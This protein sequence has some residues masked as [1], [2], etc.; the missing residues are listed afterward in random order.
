MTY[1]YSCQVC[2][3][4]W[5]VIKTVSEMDRMEACP[6]CQESGKRAFIPSRVYLS[7]TKVQ[8]PEW[9]PAFGQVVNNDY[10]RSELAKEKGYVEIGN[11]FKSTDSLHSGFERER[12]ERK[13]ARYEKA[14]DDGI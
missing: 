11:D 10:H 7:G 9:N 8:H 6:D 3:T 1:E 12:E 14:L 4:T 5:D 2:E 13:E